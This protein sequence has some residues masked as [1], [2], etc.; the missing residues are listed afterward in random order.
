MLMI[1]GEGR[2]NLG[3]REEGRG[4]GKTAE[5]QLPFSLLP[6]PFSFSLFPVPSRFSC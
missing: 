3:K 2:K 1:L 6:Y 4:K 5:P